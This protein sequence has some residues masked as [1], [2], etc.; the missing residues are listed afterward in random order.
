MPSFSSFKIPSPAN[1]QDFEDLCCDLWRRVWNDPNTQRNGRGG[2]RQNGV[3][4]CGRP[5][6]GDSWGGIQCKGKDNYAKK[7]L[8]KKEVYEE[9]EKAK[10]FEPKLSEFIIATTGPKDAKIE[11]LARIITE[12]HLKKG[13]FTVHI[14]GWEDI[15][16]RLADFP[17]VKEKHY[18]ELFQTKVPPPKDI[19]DIKETTQRILE[20]TVELRSGVSS[21]SEKIDTA[22]ISHHADLAITV[23]TP[24]YQAELDHSR[25]LLNN[26][27]PKEALEFLEG[28]KDRIWS[29]APSI[30]R[31]RLLTNIGSARLGLNQERD[32]AQLFI[33]AL[34]YNPEEEKALS[35]AALGYLLLGQLEEAR[36]FANRVVEKNPA[37]SRAYSLIIQTF[38][39]TDPLEDIVSKIPEPYRTDPEVA[40]VL[41]H[42][43]RKRDNLYESKRWFDIAVEN[44]IKGLADL[45]GALGEILIDTVIKDKLSIYGQQLDDSQKEQVNKAIELLTYAWNKMESKD[46][47]NL[48]FT[49]IV[50]RGLSKRL[51]GDIGGAIRDIE[52]ALDIDPSN[53][54]FI[55]QRA[56]LAHE[57]KDN[58]K[59]ITLLKAI[60]TSKETPKAPLLLSLVL[61]EEGKI[62]EAIGIITELLGNDPEASLKEDANRLLVQLYIAK[63][64]LESAR[65]LSDAMRASNPTNILTLVDAARLS[66]ASGKKDEAISLLM[67]AKKY[68]TDGSPAREII[69]IADEFYSLNHFEDAA[70]IYEKIVNKNLNTPLNNRLITSYYR[71]GELGKALQICQVLREKYGPLKNVSEVESASYEEIGN[72]PEAKRVCEEYLSLFPDD[73]E[74]KLRLAVVNYRS[75]YFEEVDNF[76]GSS[77]NIEA[78]YFEAGLQ[79]VSLC[80][81]RNLNQKSLDIM[82][83][84]RR[85][86]F[87]NGDAHLKYIGLFFQIDKESNKWLDFPKA[88]NGT[89]VCIEDNSGNKEWYVLDDREDADIKHHEINLKHSLA[90]KLLG[91]STDE[92]IILKENHLSKETY[93]IV[94]IK[95]KYVYALHESLSLFKK[96]FTDTPGLWEIKIGPPKEEGNLP[97]GFQT[98]LDEISRQHEFHL[99]VE[100]FYKEGTLTIGAFANLIGKNVIEVL[101]G[102]ISKRDLGIKCCIGT[103]DERNYAISLLNN[104]KKPKLIIDIISLQTLHGINAEDAIIKVFGK[105]GI[106]VS[107]VDFIQQIINERKGMPGRG[108][109]IIGKEGDKFV[110]QEVSPEDVKR[111][112]EYFENILHWIESNCDIL[113]CKAALDIN[114]AR[115]HELEEMI[116]TSFIDTVLIAT[117]P[118]HLLY[119]DDERLRSFAK[120]EFNVD[121]VWTQPILMHCLD[122]NGLEKSKYNEMIVRLV[123]S[124]YY[125]LSIDAD[126]LIEAA[127]QSSWIPSAPFTTVLQILKAPSSDEVSALNVGTIFLYELW[128]QPILPQ[129]RD[130]LILSLLDAIT[131][132]RNRRL[133]LDRLVSNVNRRFILLPLAARQIVSLINT[134]KQMHIV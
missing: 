86:Y 36:A 35:N 50:N 108:F 54:M 124:N 61:R 43:A 121:G 84:I 122:F 48:R 23:L 99:R 78:I 22:T 120:T 90:Q 31:Y 79:I 91:K 42:L 132:G 130:Y 103:I 92:E 14:F 20:H 13:L 131:D 29:T 73:F 59:A 111:S 129:R 38:P 100:Q 12:D 107:T 56:I 116:G 39:E 128:R 37:N 119:S 71:A 106:A 47:R 95:S 126:V 76:L 81:A 118:E 3:D 1:W 41:G 17:E 4:I 45:R 67:E 5:N 11:K 40:Y 105:L 125:Y 69:E 89:A 66:K 51:I 96:V 32:A 115:R 87:N 24:E 58:E 27:K 21:L 98:V 82:Y 74:M 72:L 49:W 109:M 8:T 85:K 127:R 57:S 10:S 104:H 18:S 70:S 9:V 16:G 114:K 2:Q 33:G 88:D 60:L 68:I 133:V 102:M 30:V 77:I 53:P 15:V 25:D 55:E 117:E 123:N 44:D 19:D 113:P 80:R 28:L 97:E 112:I 101:G 26:Y 94:E 7:L 6:Q 65:N 62:E 134:W 46:L 63:K 83:E 34:Q 64:D 52:T 75:N 93:R 110:K